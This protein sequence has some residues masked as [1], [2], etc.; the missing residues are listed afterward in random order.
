MTVEIPK[1]DTT[2]PADVEAW[3]GNYG[4]A[5]HYRKVVLS[6]CRE[7]IRASAAIA[8][9]KL[10]EAKIDDAARLHDSYL[11]FLR[12]CLDGRRIREEM[13]REAFVNR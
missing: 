6:S 4:Y 2:D 7:I 8:G 13:V 5:D 1:C 10:S 12:D 9:T 3:F 11:V